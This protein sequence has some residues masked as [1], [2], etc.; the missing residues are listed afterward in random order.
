MNYILKMSFRNLARNKRRSVFS[1][2]AIS[3]G[4]ALL[5]FM[6]ATIRGEMLGSLDLTINLYTG[7]LQIHTENYKD[8]NMSL[9]HADMI[10][11]PLGISEQV[12]TLEQVKAASP[13]LNASGVLAFKN[14]TI[15]IQVVGI[16]PPSA[17][18]ATYREGLVKGNFL[19]ADDHE[20]VLIGLPLATSLN[21]DVGDTI[22]LILNTSDGNADEQQFT[23]R[24]I[25]TTDTPGYDKATIF[26]PLEKA[27]T[28]TRADN[29]AS[30]I[31]ILLN[32]ME[33]TAKVKDAIHAPGYVI[34]DWEE[35][36]KLL[37]IVEKLSNAM[38][39]FFNLMVLG[40]TSTVIMNTLLMAVY[41]RTR[42][43]GILGALGMKAKQVKSLFLTEA[44]L[45]AVGGVLVGLLIG[46]PLTIYFSNIGFE[47]GDMGISANSG[48]MF[49]NKIYPDTTNLFDIISVSLAGILITILSGYYPASQAAKLE[50]VEA[51]HSNN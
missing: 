47:V 51:L 31:Y 23:I 6:S 4:T 32:D 19:T 46:I 18:N 3:I 26:M 49:G 11:N 25:Y 50:P 38:M 20:G 45:L 10:E 34:E 8:S 9:K 21:L 17:T 15:G 39:F 40:V 24:G 28:I 12:E 41:E 42:E 36:N 44:T 30:M 22:D 33:D 48:I 2:L 13:R 5:L 35:M 43:M 16:D 14:E 27:Q 7:H 29:H 37:I 1:A